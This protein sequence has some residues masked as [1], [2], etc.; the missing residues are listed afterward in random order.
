LGFIGS[1][2]EKDL[3]AR[4]T[5]V[6]PIEVVSVVVLDLILVGRLLDFEGCPADSFGELFYGAVFWS[7]IAAKD[8][9]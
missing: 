1:R 8:G 7:G 6:D 9:G 4:R 3:E 5:V 2:L